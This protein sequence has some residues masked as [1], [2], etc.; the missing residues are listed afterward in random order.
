M[1]AAT[2]K[3]KGTWASCAAGSVACSH[4]SGE[5]FSFGGLLLCCT[6]HPCAQSHIRRPSSMH[7][8]WTIAASC[9]WLHRTNTCIRRNN[10]QYILSESVVKVLTH[11]K[12]AWLPF[13]CFTLTSCR[14]APSLCL[15]SRLACQVAYISGVTKD[16]GSASTSWMPKSISRKSSCSQINVTPAQGDTSYSSSTST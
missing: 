8:C 9:V 7:A 15:R 14:W 11:K 6:V 12:N 16:S 13:F 5:V 4:H 1:P 3:Y 10:H 2:I